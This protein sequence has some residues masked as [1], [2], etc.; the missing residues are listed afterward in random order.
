MTNPDRGW[1]NGPTGTLLAA[2]LVFAVALG[3]Y[4][5]WSGKI[6]GGKPLCEIC[7]RELHP[8]NAFVTLD[9]NGKRKVSCCPR[10][11]LHHV[12]NFGGRALE[13][14]D[15][16][17]GKPLAAENAIYLEGSDIMECCDTTGFREAQGGYTDIEYDRCMPSL[18]A[19]SKKEEAEAIR[20]KHGGRIITYEQAKLSVARQIS[21]KQ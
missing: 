3:G 12:L 11:G 19:F 1:H 16:S 20:Q 9:T 17:T 6:L 5:V 7:K 14:A 18:I 8:N 4:F 15:F 21:G 13:A 10:C 2:V